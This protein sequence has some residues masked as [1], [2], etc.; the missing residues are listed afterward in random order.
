MSKL[1]ELL[2]I[3]LAVVVC[4]IAV[5]LSLTVLLILVA[6]GVDILFNFGCFDLGHEIGLI[7]A[8]LLGC[9]S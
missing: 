6:A 8:L 7:P 9:K 3:F 2:F 4:I 1:G 5:G